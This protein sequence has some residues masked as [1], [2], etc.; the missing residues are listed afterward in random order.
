MDV[1]LGR[2]II[3][4]RERIVANFNAGD[5]EAVGLLSGYSDLIDNH[6][7]LLRSLAWGDE[8]YAGNALNT[9]RT[10]AE[11]DTKAVALIEGYLDE[12]YEPNRRR[13]SSRRIRTLARKAICG[14]N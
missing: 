14:T 6:A 12:R 3:Q 11:Q 10:I 1:A 13:R 4:L 7:R 8:D 5:W 2:R 9:I